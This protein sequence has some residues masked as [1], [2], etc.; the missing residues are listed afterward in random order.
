MNPM[1]KQRKKIDSIDRKIVSLLSK[2]LSIA[3]NLKKIKKQQNLKI[4]DR[5]RERE[6]IE[7]ARAMAKQ[8]DIEPEFAEELFKKIIKY[9][10]EKQK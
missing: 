10:R 7:N 2:R 4:T 9:T 6:V 8:H 1:K 5:A 3:K